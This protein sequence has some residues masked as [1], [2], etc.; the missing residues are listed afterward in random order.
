MKAE[1]ELQTQYVKETRW[2]PTRYE[3]ALRILKEEVG[4]DDPE[5]VLAYVMEATENGKV[6]TVGSCRFRRA[7]KG[8]E[9]SR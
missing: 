8:A 9:P 4:E 3:D 6:I 5:G 7:L 2:V 1:V